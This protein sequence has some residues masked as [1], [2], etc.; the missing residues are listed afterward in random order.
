MKI[1]PFVDPLK[2]EL[3]LYPYP[4]QDKVSYHYET[5]SLLTVHT[6]THNLGYYPALVRCVDDAGTERYPSIEHLSPNALT[7]EFTGPTAVEAADFS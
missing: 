1:L 6:V 5:A 7:M 2:G 3:G 4:D